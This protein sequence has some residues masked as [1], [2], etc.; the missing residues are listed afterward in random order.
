MSARSQ[1]GIFYL[2]DGSGHLSC[3]LRHAMETS[4]W[5]QQTEDRMCTTP[6]LVADEVGMV[7]KE[8]Q[9]LFDDA[10]RDLH[11]LTSKSGKCSLR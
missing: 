3:I 7:R 11:V 9:H 5:V 2:L 1:V 4:K 8:L 10:E 6:Y